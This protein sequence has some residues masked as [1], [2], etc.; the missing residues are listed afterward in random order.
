MTR[1]TF[2]CLIPLVFTTWAMG[3][4]S[5][6]ARA[7]TYVRITD[8]AG[9][10]HIAQ[11]P[12]SIGVTGNY[13]NSDARSVTVYIYPAKQNAMGNW[14]PSGAFASSGATNVDG[15]GGSWAVTMNSPAMASG[16]DYVLYAVSRSG[17][18]AQLDTSEYIHVI[19]N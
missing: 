14:V 19:S 3:F 2:S 4:A 5:P 8:P 11:S 9:G 10:D 13:L 12:G 16:K 17:S 15:S 7:V 18:G 1:R 6:A